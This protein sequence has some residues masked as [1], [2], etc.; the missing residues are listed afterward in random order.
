[1][2]R[3]GAGALGRTGAGAG[4]P[5]TGGEQ[6]GRCH[7][8]GK[9][10]RL[11]PAPPASRALRPCA[12]ASLRRHR[13]HRPLRPGD[14]LRRFDPEMPREGRLEPLAMVLREDV[15]PA[16]EQPL[17]LRVALGHE[18]DHQ[19]P[20]E[21]GEILGDPL[22]RH[23][24]ADREVVH[25]R[26]RQKRVRRT[27]L[28]QRAPLPVRPAQRG[29]RVGE[30]GQQRQNALLSRRTHRAVV[31]LHRRRIDVERDHR[32]GRLAG[33]PA[34]LPGVR[35]QIPHHPGEAA[36]EQTGHQLALRGDRGVG[37]VVLA[38]VVRP[39]S[40]RGLPA[41]SRDRAPEAVH[42]ADRG[43]LAD[44]PALHP[45]GGGRIGVAPLRR[46]VEVDVHQG[47]RPEPAPPRQQAG[48]QLERNA[49]EVGPEQ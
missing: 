8:G 5:A 10:R 18:L 47:A 48:A 13:I 31:T 1:M 14:R 36:S 7:R 44:R 12:S 34:V 27:A 23:V 28:L 2:G 21:P 39:L 49:V 16:P 30:V 43:G 17:D 42:Q 24:A 29:R 6:S 40:A 37:V 4:V 35:A 41:E 9:P 11:N 38:G 22:Q 15:L 25:Q 19:R 20:A 33:H 32:L 3:S 45:H 46:R 26:Q